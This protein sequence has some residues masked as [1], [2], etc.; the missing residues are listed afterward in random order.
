MV[1]LGAGGGPFDFGVTDPSVL[2]DKRDG[3]ETSRYKMWFE[4]RSGTNGITSTI[5]YGTSSDGITW[6]SF[7]PC[8]GLNA[9]I[10]AVRVA[11]PSVLIDN[12]VYKMWFESVATSVGGN[13]GAQAIGYA[14]SN[15]GINWVVKGPNGSQGM[16][17]QVVFQAA[18]GGFQTLGGTMFGL[19]K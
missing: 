1:T 9:N 4:G 11:D 5:M 15:D 17:A 8:L 2:V 12:D 10:S 14:E 6:N 16:T 13:D 3:E 18:G 19:W 7:T